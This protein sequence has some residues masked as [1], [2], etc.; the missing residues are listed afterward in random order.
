MK[1]LL[2]AVLLLGVSSS[3]LAAELTAE[4]LQ[5]QAMIQE[6]KETPEGE[7]YQKMNAFKKHIR[8]MNTEQKEAALAELGEAL[9]TQTQLQ[10]RTQERIN[11][12]NGEGEQ[13]HI[14]TQERIQLQTA[15]EQLQL[16]NQMQNQNR[17]GKMGIGTFGSKSKK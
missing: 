12:G 11:E 2:L 5:V 9:Q 16:Q 8:L 13:V 1:E 17:V 4:Q 15:Q 14:R 3:L 10:T 7:R 6:I